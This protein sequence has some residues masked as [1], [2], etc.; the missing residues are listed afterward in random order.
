MTFISLSVNGNSIIAGTYGS[1]LV[2][3]NYG[4][5][6]T[7]KNISGLPSGYAVNALVRR[8]NY[9]FAASLGGVFRSSDNGSNWVPVNNGMTNNLVYSLAANGSNIYAGSGDG[10]FC[11]TNN[12]AAWTHGTN[13]G[14]TD[15]Y[16]L[17]LAAVGNNLFAGTMNGL[18]LSTD[19]GNTWTNTGLDYK[20]IYALVFNSNEIYA[21]AEGTGVWRRP[22]SE[23]V[24][25]SDKII[26]LPGEY[27]LSQNYP[28]PFNPS[29]TINYS[30]LKAGN[31]KLTVFNAIG[32]RVATILNEYKPAGNYSVKFNAANLVSGIYLYRLESGNYSSAKKLI[33]L[34]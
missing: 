5:S 14:L 18:F 24:N 15:L 25:V 27:S 10:V 28:N 22:L 33:L 20:R 17:S 3:D 31:V 12:G 32:S 2:S 23:L 13:N 16:V 1:V 6:W 30:L 34:K 9:I 29:T 8:S 4:A 26:N 21:G 11:S 19:N 7:Q